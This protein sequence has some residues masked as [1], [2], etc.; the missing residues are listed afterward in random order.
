MPDASSELFPAEGALLAD[1]QVDL[2]GGLR[3]D[4]VEEPARLQRTTG[5][6]RVDVVAIREQG[7]HER[8]ERVRSRVDD[9]VRVVR[10][11]GP[12]VV[13]ARHRAGD[14]V[15]NRQLLE[16]ANETAPGVGR[17]S[18]HGCLLGL[19]KLLPAFYILP[20]ARLRNAPRARQAA[21]KRLARGLL[22]QCQ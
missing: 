12:T 5:G 6:R 21:P 4:H 9:D 16:A 17:G 14:H 1:D 8:V 13:A 22:E 20:T 10:G 11:S 18:G 15:G 2:E 3:I 7:G 19:A